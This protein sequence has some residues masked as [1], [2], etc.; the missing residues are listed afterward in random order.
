[1]VNVLFILADALRADRLHCCGNPYPT[2]P[3]L[4]RLAS[5]GALFTNVIANA[6]HTVPGL[7][8]AFTGLYVV[9]HGIGDQQAFGQWSQ[10][11]QGWQPPFH[12]LRDAGYIVAGDDPEF[13]H[14]LGFESGGRDLHAAMEQYAGRPFFLWHRSEAT[15]LPYNPPAPLDTAFLPA[16]FTVSDSLAQRLQVVRRSLIVHKPGLLSR[17]EAGPTD[18]IQREGYE[19]TVGIAAF[20]P[21][22]R[23][24]IVALYDG[25]VRMLDDEIAA[26]VD[27]L[28]RLGILDH[29]L[30]VITADHGEQL[31]E[32]GAVGHSSCSLEGNLYD[33]NIRVPLILRCPR[34]LPHGRII[35]R[36]VSQV[37]I[38][39][40]L[41][42]LLDLPMPQPCDARSLLPLV[43]DPQC[44]FPEDAYAET[45]PCGW[46]ALEGDRRMIWCLRWPPWK[47]IRYSDPPQEDRHELFHLTVDPAETDNQIQ[48]HPEVARNLQARLDS[49]LAR[50]PVGI[51][52][53]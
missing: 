9:S 1:M 25:C 16:D 14:P 51:R 44:D 12:V 2:S 53:V 15:H 5:E 50:R 52:P 23:P 3:T 7:V 42:D 24:A 40:T 45:S 33:E 46:Q 11:W 30:V 37:D 36:Q 49:W 4:D 31:L 38:M 41:F 47:L 18:A 19:R 22:E 29:T 20:D 48:N 35:Q 10:R 28:A 27:H 39:A 21:A 6:N 8:S 26:Y 34:L 17:Q 13:Y 32:R 43:R